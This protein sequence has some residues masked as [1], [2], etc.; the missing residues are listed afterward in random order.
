MIRF[1]NTGSEATMLAIRA[2]RSWTRKDKFA[3]IEGG[4]NGQHDYVL[5][6]S[7]MSGRVAGPSDKPIPVAD[8][9]GI[10]KFVLDNTI[11]LPFN[12]INATV[13]I[14]K[15]HAHELAAVMIEPLTGFGMGDIPADKEYLE[16]LRKV[17][18]E[19]NIVLI[20]DEVVTAFRI[21]GMGGAVKYYGIA[22]DLDCIGKPIGGGFPIGAFGGRRDIMQQTLDPQANPEYKIFQSG[23][24]SGNP[25]T[26][27][28]GLACLTELE[29]KDY[30][31]IDNLAEKV[32]VGLR[33]IAA[34][35]GVEVQITGMGSMFYLHFNNKPVRN[36]RDKIKDDMAKNR[37][38]SLGLI[39]NGVYLPPMHP[40]AIC[41]AHKEEDIDY[42]L[43]VAEKV[44]KEMEK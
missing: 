12:D 44:L 9:A 10:P 3:K 27:T 14:I 2:A 13:S 32:R 4:Y 28:A 7:I 18:K 35:Q 15:E 20:Y 25:V 11:V 5:M 31:Y 39:V 26:M 42:I 1:C 22:P 36:N 24:F 23:T 40:A 21:G 6:S 41:F 17:T 8:S 30:S 29:T 33:K 38:F 43:S 19:N 37:E 16:A 34:E